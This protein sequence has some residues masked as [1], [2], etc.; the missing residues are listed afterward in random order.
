MAC[1]PRTWGWRLKIFGPLYERALGWARHRRAPAYLT[2]LSFIEAIIFPVHAGSD[3]G[4]DVRGEAASAAFWFATLSLA[5]SMV[6]ALVGYALGHYAFE[7]VKPLFAALGMVAWHRVG[8]RRC[9]GEDGRNRRGRCSAL[10]VLAGFT[11]IPM[12]VFTWASG[13]VGVPMLQYFAS[14][15]IGRGKRV[16]LIAAAIRIGGAARRSGAAPLHRADRLGG[17][18]A[19]GWR[20]WAWLIWRDTTRR[21]INDDAD[22]LSCRYG[23]RVGGLQQHRGRTPRDTAQRFDTAASRH[24]STARQRQC[25]AWRHAVRHR[26]PQRHG[27]A[28]PRRMER[29]RPAL[30][31][32]SGT[33]P[34]PVSARR[35]GFDNASRRH[36]RARRRS[37][38]RPPRDRRRSATTSLRRRRHRSA[39]AP[40]SGAATPV[41]PASASAG[42]GRPTA[43]A[44]PLT[45]PANRPSRASTSPA[46]AARR[47]KRRPMAWSCIPAAGLVGYGELIIIK[48]NERGCRPTATTVRAWSTK[49]RS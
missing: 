4:A 45:S 30:H 23:H 42:A 31:D 44:R 33:E 6:G 19:A 29:D 17:D 21:M 15:L 16:Y 43:T 41:P 24:R 37:R 11:P 32:L 5:G 49:A 14:M 35:F 3:A 40:S 48:H 1:V 25:Q 46:T 12:K 7:V 28:R 38:R 8:H 10:L 36:D 18:G 26:L 34:A 20:W 39:T 47:C 13:I 2:G 9:P 27:R 22:R